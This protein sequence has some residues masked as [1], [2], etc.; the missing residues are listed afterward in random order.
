LLFLSIPVLY[1]LSVGPVALIWKTFDLDKNPITQE[2][3][4]FY[5]P[6][7]NYVRGNDELPA[8]VLKRY[9]ELWVGPD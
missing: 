5:A 2:V 7:E 4:A 3:A 9:V 6:L 8:K 1:V